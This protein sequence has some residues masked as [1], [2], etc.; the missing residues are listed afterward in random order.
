MSIEISSYISSNLN[1]FANFYAH[2]IAN[3]QLGNTQKTT[4]KIPFFFYKVSENIGR[5]QIK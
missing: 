2:E 1:D 5:I 3:Q 4:D